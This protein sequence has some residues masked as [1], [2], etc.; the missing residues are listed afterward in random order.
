MSSHGTFFHLFPDALFTINGFMAIIGS[1]LMVVIRTGYVTAFIQVMSK[2]PV[3]KEC[4]TVGADMSTVNG[5]WEN[6]LL[7]VFPVFFLTGIGSAIG[8]CVGNY[9][10]FK[11][12]AG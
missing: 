5:W 2:P 8:T 1:A 4:E 9:Q 11:N 6:K 12:L 3:V 7:R 10:I